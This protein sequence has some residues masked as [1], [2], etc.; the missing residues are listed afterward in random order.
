M[1]WN[2]PKQKVNITKMM[3]YSVI[4]LVI[5]YV[6]WRIQK[7]WIL[8]GINFL[9]TI[10][11]HISMNYTVPSFYTYV[12]SFVIGNIISLVCVR[13]FADKYNRKIAQ[14]SSP[15]ASTIAYYECP[16]CHDSD[17]RNNANGS[18]TCD[19]CGFTT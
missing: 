4:P 8:L 13:Y 17:I 19:N 11:F 6:G 14:V 7:F 5:I 3:I 2:P 18:V 15:E 10:I 9:F 16:R 12:M 1:I